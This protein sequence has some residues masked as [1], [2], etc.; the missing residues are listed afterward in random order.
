M[1]YNFSG[2]DMNAP[3]TPQFNFGGATGASPTGTYNFNIPSNMGGFSNLMDSYT[4]EFN[5]AGP[6]AAGFKLG[7]NIPTF[8]LGLMGLNTIG[9]LWGA[10]QANKLARDQMDF[11][12]TIGNANLNNQIKSYNTALSD[13]ART[14]AV[15]EGRSQEDA[16]AYID[17]NKLT[18]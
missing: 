11:T 6:A 5:P 13:R 18:R 2:L 7:A 10:F 1:T 8:Q 3:V 16:Q 14:R 9:N 15:M 12:K 17:A 4:P